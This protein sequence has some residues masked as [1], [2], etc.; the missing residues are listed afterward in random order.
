MR[1]LLL[2]LLASLLARQSVADS[3][4]DT[5]LD[6]VL[7][8]AY[9]NLAAK[10][11]YTS[12]LQIWSTVGSEGGRV[13]VVA[14]GRDPS[15]L[16]KINAMLHANVSCGGGG[17]WAQAGAACTALRA[18]FFDSI[19]Y[20]AIRDAEG[21]GHLG[22][23]LNEAAL[24]PGYLGRLLYFSVDTA[25][26]PTMLA[27]LRTAGNVSLAGSA[28]SGSPFTRVIV[29]KPLGADAKSSASLAAALSAEVPGEGRLLVMDHYL[30]KTGLHMALEMRRRMASAGLGWA[31]LVRG[32]AGSTDESVVL[33]E[34]TAEGR[35]GFYNGVGVLRD[36][37]Q[38]HVSLF[39]AAVTGVPA[40]PWGVAS[41]SAAYDQWDVQPASLRVGRYAGYN[42]HV[43]ADR[44]PGGSGAFTY[45]VSRARRCMLYGGGAHCE[46]VDGAGP[47][48]LYGPGFRTITGV[49]VMLG[50]AGGGS[51]NVR[52]SKAAGARTGY[53]RHVPAHRGRT[54][55][56]PVS[57][58]YHMQGEVRLPPGVRTRLRDGTP[59]ALPH[60]APAVI[61]T[62]VC[63]PPTSRGDAP[64]PDP[65]EL[66]GDG[67]QWP[68]DWQTSYA[69]EAGVW[70][71][72]PSLP[73]W[74]PSPAAGTASAAAVLARLRVMGH[75]AGR[76]GGDAYTRMI[77]AGLAGD[78]GG[79]ASPA[80]AVRT[81]GL[82]ERLVGLADAAAA[83]PLLSY[84]VGLAAS[85]PP[86]DD[87]STARIMSPPDDPAA[88]LEGHEPVA[89]AR[90]LQSR[91]GVEGAPIV[92]EHAVGDA[93][94]LRGL[95]PA[96]FDPAAA[97]STPAVA[98]RGRGPRGSGLDK[99]VSDFVAAMWSVLDENGPPTVAMYVSDPD[100]AG[101]GAAT[102]RALVARLMA[103][104]C[105][106]LAPWAGTRIWAPEAAPRSVAYLRQALVDPL[107]Q[108]LGAASGERGLPPVTLWRAGS[109]RGAPPSELD[110]CVVRLPTPR[111]QIPP[112][113][114]L[115]RHLFVLVPSATMTAYGE[116]AAVNVD[117]SSGEV[118][119]EGLAYVPTVPGEEL[120]RLPPALEREIAELTARRTGT[121]R[122]YLV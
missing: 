117:A 74:V 96:A 3:V 34:E 72:T 99:F 111:E 11:L 14:A 27:T 68:S 58:T 17:A 88:L 44:A 54:G 53:H 103:A 65:T 112:S 93:G 40:A 116:E 24:R 5:S 56:G 89:A 121:S 60:N 110:I 108:A 19:T 73:G 95:P 61:V 84:A 69:R 21:Y 10:Y 82:W 50:L 66:T 76:A 42:A 107:N 87:D 15:G 59:I 101:G 114:A 18:T 35:T 20:V 23:V 77:A 22:A 7:F 47:Y 90:Y 85:A 9:S 38:S 48:D 36:M 51:L 25:L 91:H 26:V 98:V 13:R 39:L 28:A 81:W 2:A 29:E 97:S 32:G 31:A 109:A 78:T 6:V 86:A 33:E 12:L 52:V 67:L 113:L 105:R 64:W 37:L 115:A 30:G 8:G 63:P 102:L 71:V 100:E 49:D 80:E 4:A 122:V 118:W 104:D 70:W 46:G 62:G 119:T 41:R 43:T 16:E 79:F 83:G 55:C 120:T 57:V 1:R 45:N 92:T 94:W 75:T 106:A